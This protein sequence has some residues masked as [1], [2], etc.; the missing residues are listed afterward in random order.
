MAVGQSRELRLHYDPR[1]P[2][3]LSTKPFRT[4]LLW[5]AVATLAI[6]AISGFVA[7]VHGALSALLGGLVN[8]SAGVV[9]AFVLAVAPPRSAGATITAMF[10]A[11]GAKVL[12]IIALLG[13]V[14]SKY[15]DAVLP[16]FLAAFVVT[17]LLFSVALIVRD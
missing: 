10:R 14:L 6:A 16:A 3:P 7:G 1:V 4:V 12:V 5:Q 11:E 2:K 9:F 13:V 8:L 17:V 15:R